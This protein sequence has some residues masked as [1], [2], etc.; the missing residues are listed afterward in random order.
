M[1]HVYGFL[2]RDDRL[3]GVFDLDS[4]LDLELDIDLDLDFDLDLD[5]DFLLDGAGGLKKI[6]LGGLAVIRRPFVVLFSVLFLF[7]FM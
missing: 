6:F 7:S 2:L 4:D 3:V 5:G 1:K